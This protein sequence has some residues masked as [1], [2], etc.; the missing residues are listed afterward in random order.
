MER[1]D[2]L[3]RPYDVDGDEIPA[4]PSTPAKGEKSVAKAVAEAVFHRPRIPLK[5]DGA[6]STFVMYS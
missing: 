1:H 6:V 3:S 5:K 4:N 2:A